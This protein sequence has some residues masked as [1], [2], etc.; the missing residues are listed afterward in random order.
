MPFNPGEL[1]V[2]GSIIA[3]M[4]VSLGDMTGE[5]RGPALTLSPGAAV[6]LLAVSQDIVSFILIGAGFLVD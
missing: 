3:R 4:V 2:K 5:G 6:D 1:D